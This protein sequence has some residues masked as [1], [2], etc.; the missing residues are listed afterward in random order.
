M[1]YDLSNELSRR[2][3]AARVKHLWQKGG[4]VELTDKSRRSLT[5]N[6]YLHAILGA[7]ALETGNS[8]EVVKLEIYKKKVNPDLY[9]RTKSDPLLGEI[10]VVRSGRDLT[11]EE[12]SL[13][14]DRYKK[15]CAEQGIFLPEPGDEELLRQIEWEMSRAAKYL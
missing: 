7:L 4:I 11:K 14:I 13:S 3:F 15:F 8:L 1:L 2:Q 10:E 5:Q 12:M 6:S 9:L